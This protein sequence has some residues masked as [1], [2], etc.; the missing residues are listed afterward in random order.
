[1]HSLPICFDMWQCRQTFNK[2]RT[3]YY[4]SCPGGVVIVPANRTEDLG[5]ESHQ[6]VRFQRNSTLH[7]FNSPLQLARQLIW[8]WLATKKERNSTLQCVFLMPQF[9][10]VLCWLEEK[11]KLNFVCTPPQKKYTYNMS[12]STVTVCRIVRSC[13]SVYDEYAQPQCT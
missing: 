3:N 12:K 10:L 4:H 1:M 5:F 11:M 8:T 9:A 7:P 2:L 13:L 6:G